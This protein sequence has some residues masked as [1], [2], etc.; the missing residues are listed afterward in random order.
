VITELQRL[1]LTMFEQG[2]TNDTIA[3]ELGTSV[4]AVENVLYRAR[5]K[6]YG[7]GGGRA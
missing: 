2:E 5:R 6:V 4:H 1:V 3:Y 7:E